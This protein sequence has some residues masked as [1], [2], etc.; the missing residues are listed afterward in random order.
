V[1]H[2]IFICPLA[3]FVW[4]VIKE[5]V[6]WGRS[7]KSVKEFN[8]EFLLERGRKDNG[9]VFFLFGAV[10]W[11]LWLNRNDW[12]FRNKL[13]SSPNANLHKLIFFMQRWVILSSGA[14]RGELDKLT[15][16]SCIPLEASSG[17]A[18]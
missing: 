1:D 4:S 17:V 9:R 2:L 18:S 14:A 5:G 13:V 3:G 10:C 12:V 11:T 6:G 8:D 16:A 15:E 7:P